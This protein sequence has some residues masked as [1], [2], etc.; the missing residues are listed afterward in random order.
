MARHLRGRSLF[1]STIL[2]DL[3]MDG[4]GLSDMAGFY[5]S[6]TGVHS[7]SS[8]DTATGVPAP[9]GSPVGSFTVLPDGNGSTGAAA[10]DPPASLAAAASRQDANAITIAASTYTLSA[11]PSTV[12][13]G[14]QVT[15]T[16]TRSGDLPAETVYFSTLATG[17]ATY[18]EGDYATTSGGAP[19]N[20]AV[21][22]SSGSTTRTVTLNILNDGVPDSGETF[23]AI[24]QRNSSDSTNVFLAQSGSVTINDPPA[25]NT[26]YT[27]SPS[28]TS[29]F[30][31]GR[32]TFTITRTGDQP[33]ETVYFSAWADSAS[34]A[35]GDYRM[36]NGAKPENIAVTF[37]SGEDDETV[38][39]SILSDSSADA[40][41]RFRAIVQKNP[42]SSDPAVNVAVTG[43]ITIT[44]PNTT[45]SLGPATIT[46][47]EGV[48]TITFTVTRTGDKPDETI[49]A[50]TLLDSASSP[51]DYQGLVDKA[52]P[53]TFG[54]SSETFTVTINNDAAPETT[55]HFRVM[56]GRAGAQSA[57]ALDISDVYVTDDD[58]TPATTDQVREGTDTLHSL[59]T[60]ARVSGT[61]DAEPI[62]GDGTVSDQQGGM[63][64]KDWYKVTLDPG[65]VYT[66]DATA[67]SITTG[68]VV[69]SLYDATATRVKEPVEGSAPSFTFDMTGQTTSKVYYL[70]VSAGGPDPTWLTATG[71]YSIGVTAGGVPPPPPPPNGDDYRDDDED[72]TAP[73]GD[74]KPGESV[75]GIINSADADDRLGDKDVFAVELVAGQVYDFRLQST[76]VGGTALPSGVFTIR[77]DNFVQLELSGS[78]SDVHEF[79]RADRGGLYYVRVGSGGSSSSTGGYK[80]SITSVQPSAVPDDWADTPTD[81]GAPGPLAPGS[82]NSGVIET[83]GDKD[84]FTVFLT[85]GKIYHFSVESLGDSSAGPMGTVALSLR[86]PGN[87]D[88]WLTSRDASNRVGFDY[89]ITQ[90]GTYFVRVGA[91]DDST[92]TGAYR[93]SVGN[94]RTPPPPPPPPPPGASPDDIAIAWIKDHYQQNK[95]SIGLIVFDD[96]L[97]FVQSLAEGMNETK[98]IRII[99]YIDGV[100]FTLGIVADGKDAID[101]ILHPTKYSQQ[102][103]IFVELTTLMA[104]L[105]VAT[106]GI[107]FPGIG[108]V[109]GIVWELGAR[110]GFKYLAAEYYDLVIAPSSFMEAELLAGLHVQAAA[111]S[112][113]TTEPFDVADFVIFDDQYYLRTYPAVGEAI[114]N[115]LFG[116]AYSHFLAIGVD[117]GYKPN[118]SQ[119]L[120]RADLVIRLINDDPH[121]LGNTVLYT[122][123]LGLLAGDG[124]N[125]AEQLVANLLTGTSGAAGGAT[126]DATLS[127]LAHRKAV[128]LAV[129]THGDMIAAVAAFDSAWALSWS[130]GSDFNQVLAGPVAALLGVGIP[131]SAYDLFVVAS[132]SGSPADVLAQLQAQQG[133]AAGS[134]DTFGIAEFA[135]LWVIIV[136][137]R[138]DGVSPT[139]PGADTL[140]TVTVYG[141]D[142]SETQYA[143]L[144]EGRLFGLAGDD[145]LVGGAGNDRLDGGD[146]NDLLRGGFGQNVLIGGAGNDSFFV[147]NSTDTIIELEG[148]GFDR[149]YASVPYT[150]AAGVYVETLSTTDDTGTAPLALAGN[151]LDNRIIGNAGANLL[152]GMGGIDTLEGLAGDD[153]Y[154]VDHWSDAIVEA[155]GQGYDTVYSSAHYR[156]AAGSEVEVLSALDRLGTNLLDLAGNEYGNAIF[157]NAG[158]NQLSGF[159]GDDWLDGGDGDDRLDGGAG[160]D[161]AS[162]ITAGAAVAVSLATA[163]AQNTG[164]AGI[165][166]LVD[167]ENLFGSGFGDTL[168]GNALA[169]ILEGRGGADTMRGGAGD[170][171]YYVDDAGDVV[172]ELAGEGFD[173]V[174]T[175][176]AAYSLLGTQIERLGTSS[177]IAHEF[178]GSA[179]DN[180]VSGGGGNDVLLLQDGG[181]D[182]ALG[183]GG[184]DVLYFGAA[185]GGTDIADGGAGRDALVLQ[186]NVTAVL[187]SANLREIE[188]V[189]LQSGANTKFGDTANNLYDFNLTM[190]DGNVAA[191]VQLIVNASSLRAGEDFTFNGSAELDGRFLVYG[192]HGVDILKGGAGNDIFFFEGQRWGA[193]DR[194]DG[195]AG[196]DA[197]V[198]AGAGG[199]NQIAFGADSFTGIESISLNNQLASDPS[200]KPSYQLVLNNGNVAPGGT[201]IVNGSS[202]A[203]G[204]VA[205]ID[206]RAVQS[207][208]LVLFGGGGHDVLIGGAGADLIVGGGGQDSLTGGAGA[209]TFRYDSVSD[210]P[211]GATDLI[212]DFSTGL[213]K[214][215]LSRID[216]N[217]LLAGDQAFTW[218]GANAFS[219]A[220]GELRVRDDGYYRYLEGDTNGD[221]QA[222]FAVAFYA[223]AAPQVPADFLL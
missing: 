114:A 219:G 95:T 81:S 23:R 85:A 145:Q 107:F 149:V 12:T 207:G 124:I 162:Y 29:M 130:D 49:Y 91:G 92:D 170:D 103:T 27:I 41:E 200:Q 61:I 109:A 203:A 77:D 141:S 171:T 96:I 78:G 153:R 68:K 80:L 122:N 83:A 179:G 24:V 71:N 132:Q 40:G 31:G 201:L 127:A 15:F 183:G 53:F 8:G 17:T 16:I 20:I 63:V 3:R 139:V 157:G 194:V 155:A 94:P 138:M 121:A 175:T 205:N 185:F 50:S 90:S 113:P 189:S 158:A 134:F 191:G 74:I 47:N 65:K 86:G 220:A 93:V 13:E 204:Q 161:T 144:R 89:L 82:S 167:V 126:L 123:Q 218:I 216:A 88:N 58:G 215:D 168:T 87:F 22:F 195:G 118:E 25:Q 222:D 116:S 106:G 66:F 9:T 37:S 102:K 198:I 5:R 199:L 4:A 117:L 76:S 182:W 151:E 55:E 192:G 69:I 34:Y 101:E 48:G 193:G 110:D 172:V 163:A 51:G 105:G 136:G 140:A 99:N 146:G 143:G 133:W 33:A 43:Y 166:T 131:D 75:T 35:E 160:N 212:A 210:S 45:Y 188:S 137:D 79:F 104:G 142:Q 181:S 10:A 209:D 111:V 14:N 97:D 129:N 184:N 100:F 98:A 159:G 178:R 169:N 18:G 217:A 67:T 120:T 39:L 152:Y 64:D 6:L 38:T 108:L 2:A 164:G 154:V 26:I 174:C 84:Y 115:G 56:I 30:E 223:V 21:S 62:S 32:V 54:D 150:L 72:T 214:V 197:L 176:L 46:V 57:Q 196:R 1:D 59:T 190:N 206:G 186:G 11:S 28:A 177:D 148:S 19:S 42:P 125:S 173:L 202:I 112:T 187:G 211:A 135:G 221:G 119:S 70:A 156:L 180:H 73:L 128:D 208:A 165:D 60:S 36:L 44:N 213:D 7:L 52:V 147:A